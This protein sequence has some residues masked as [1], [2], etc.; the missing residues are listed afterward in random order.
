MS[1]SRE[2]DSTFPSWRR[3]TH[4]SYRSRIRANY[5]DIAWYY[6]IA[7]GAVDA[8]QILISVFA[9]PAPSIIHATYLPVWKMRGWK[10]YVFFF[11]RP[12]APGIYVYVNNRQILR[13]CS[14][15]RLTN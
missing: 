3:E 12:K 11:T 14:L 7:K 6:I 5:E 15:K 8:M 1:K 13:A 9:R 2:R 10:T 4:K